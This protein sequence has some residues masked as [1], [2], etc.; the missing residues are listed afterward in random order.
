MKTLPV[1]PTVS[2]HD[3]NL[4]V[5]PVSVPIMAGLHNPSS[6]TV[7]SIGMNVQYG[8]SHLA[9][10]MGTSDMQQQEQGFY[11]IQ[12]PQF[13]PLDQPMLF[14]R[15]QFVQQLA[16]TTGALSQQVQVAVIMASATWRMVN[17]V[18][19]QQRMVYP[20][21]G[22]GTPGHLFTRMQAHP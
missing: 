12:P 18:L 7:P 8:P 11:W 6:M 22:P 2:A 9:A 21:Y 14:P 17:T 1:Q 4:M 20:G 3:G 16:A 15:P 19:Q 13:G 5:P 10:Q